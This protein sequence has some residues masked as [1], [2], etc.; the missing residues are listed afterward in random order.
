M[1]DNK[2]NASENPA[3]GIN[4]PILPT[5]PVRGDEGKPVINSPKGRKNGNR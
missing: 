5:K 3:K 2:N 4:A 1:T